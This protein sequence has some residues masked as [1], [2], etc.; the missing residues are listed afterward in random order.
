MVD[1][2]DDDEVLRGVAPALGAAEEMVEGEVAGAVPAVEAL[3]LAF[4]AATGLEQLGAELGVGAVLP[5]PFPGAR[6]ERREAAEVP[7]ASHGLR[8]RR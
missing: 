7:G 8:Q 5:F 6:A 4:P 1:G 2:A 3:G